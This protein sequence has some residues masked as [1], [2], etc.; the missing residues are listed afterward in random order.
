M[1]GTAGAVSVVISGDEGRRECN[2]P[3]HNE[4]PGECFCFVVI[5]ERPVACDDDLV[6][7]I[8]DDCPCHPICFGHGGVPKENILTG[9]KAM[10]SHCLCDS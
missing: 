2:S 8:V 6:A 3:V 5:A 4:G 9:R 7:I 10:I 1:Y